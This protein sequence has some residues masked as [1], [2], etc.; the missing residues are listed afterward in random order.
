VKRIVSKCS[1]NYYLVQ[2]QTYVVMFYV[3]CCSNSRGPVPAV[4]R[5]QAK[6]AFQH[7]SVHTLVHVGLDCKTI[8]FSPTCECVMKMCQMLCMELNAII[9]YVIYTIYY[10]TNFFLRGA[11]PSLQAK[12]GEGIQKLR[13]TA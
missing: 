9:L 13:K 11:R 2:V 10:S 7:C 6:N 3:F 4:P 5:S 1:L 8:L 12:L